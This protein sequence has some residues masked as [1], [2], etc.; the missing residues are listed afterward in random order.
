MDFDAP[1]MQVAQR[2]L[3][4]F[5]ENQRSYCQAKWKGFEGIK[6]VHP[7]E[8]KEDRALPGPLCGSTGREEQR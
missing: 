4:D 5:G 1:G 2:R 3:H 6:L 7:C 8:P